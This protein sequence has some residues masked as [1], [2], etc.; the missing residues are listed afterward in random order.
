[1]TAVWEKTR[2]FN[3]NCFIS[4]WGYMPRKFL[5]PP[6][7]FVRKYLPFCFFVLSFPLE[8]LLYYVPRFF[9]IPTLPEY[10]SFL[11]FL[12]KHSLVHNFPRSRKPPDWLVHRWEY[13]YP[14]LRNCSSLNQH[15]N[16]MDIYCF[17]RI[18]S[19]REVLEDRNSRQQKKREREIQ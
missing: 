4:Q 16:Y 9:F 1:M 13:K 10:F 15:I 18:A 3:L 19:E 7:S 8:F 6:P 2:K 14:V 5:L 12:Q 17:S 11:N